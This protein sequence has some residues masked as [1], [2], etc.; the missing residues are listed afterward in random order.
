[1]PYEPHPTAADL[2]SARR[3]TAA[4]PHDLGLPSGW[5]RLRRVVGL[6]AVLSLIAAWQAIGVSA[7]TVD[8]LRGD[9]P[10]GDEVRAEMAEVADDR[11][12]SLI[13]LTAAE[14]DLAEV[15]YARDGLDDEQ[16][17][18]AAEIEAATDNLR[19]LA[20]ETFITGGD[21]AAIEYL[22]AVGGASDF[23]W[24]QYLV[25][26]HA[27]SSQVAVERL[28]TLRERAD[29]AVLETIN[30]AE[31]LRNE[32]AVLEAE[33]VTLDDR[34]DTLNEL[35]PLADAW[36]RTAVAVAE[37]QWGIA[38]SDRWEKLRRC[39]STDNYQAINPSGVYRGAYQFDFATWQ[40]VGG[41]GDPAAAPPEEQDARARELYARRGHQPW[42]E[43]G[44]FLV[45]GDLE[46]GDLED[47]DPE[48]GEPA[49]APDAEA[50]TGADQPTPETDGGETG[51]DE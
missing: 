37:G 13:S 12:Q 23:S 22:A 14:A 9:I 25:R 27:G 26:N 16:R 39:E 40:T 30:R 50:S 10:T 44:R 28:R 3:V 34:E 41:T 43:C 49:D 42:P 45:D 29:Q 32:I 20:I 24:R 15:L 18:L 31:T 38:P 48:T 1:M 17:R 2:E 36:D 19:R 11:L 35:L 4:R 5:A 51:T 33:I 8:D 6:L 21:V 47:E 7:E 46:L